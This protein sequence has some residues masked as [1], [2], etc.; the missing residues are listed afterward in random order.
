MALSDKFVL[1]LAL[2]SILLGQEK[3]HPIAGGFA[4][5]NGWRITP[6]GKAIPTEDLVL[7]TL[8]S[9]DGRS[10]IALHAGYNPHGLMVVDTKTGEAVQRIPLE[11]A[12][13]G[14]AWSR[15]AES[16]MSP[17]AMPPV[18]ALTTVRPST[19][20]TTATDASPKRPPA[21]WK[22]PWR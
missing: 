6:L 11:T 8:V 10:V 2:V 4:L 9:K 12:W 18:S 20:S 22:R 16:F 21:N 3:P 17:G 19:S 7:D 15:T 14:M 13:H 5:P 1:A